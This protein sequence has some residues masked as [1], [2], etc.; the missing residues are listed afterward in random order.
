M[1][2]PWAIPDGRRACRKWRP[3]C[4]ARVYLSLPLDFSVV[5]G[6][7][8]ISFYFLKAVLSLRHYGFLLS[9]VLVTVPASQC[10]L[11]LTPTLYNSL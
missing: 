4:S 2:S 8:R 5:S 7:V 6:S 3:H 11:G 9:D 1:V 10:A